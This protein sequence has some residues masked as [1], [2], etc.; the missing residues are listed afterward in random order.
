MPPDRPARV[1]E[2]RKPEPTTSVT[3][4][5][6]VR[7]STNVPLNSQGTDA[8]KKIVGRKRGILTDAT[9]P[10]L[11]ATVTITAANLSENA[12]GIDLLDQAQKNYPA[13]SKCCGDTGFRNAV[14]EH[15]ANLGT[16]IEVVDPNPGVRGF[17]VVKRR[18]AVDRS[19]GWIMMRRRLT[20]DYET[21]PAGPEAV[22]HIASID[23]LT[24]RRA[25][26][27]TPARRGLV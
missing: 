18:W 19:L 22:I 21:L 25:D 13:I 4:T 24:K 15:G 12:L 8:G 3:D 20:R 14:V 1:M 7:I 23:N 11:A 10:V 26:E 16:D 2:R 17:H 27:T 9:G 6:S 5:Q